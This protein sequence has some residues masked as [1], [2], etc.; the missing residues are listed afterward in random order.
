MRV[1]NERLLHG[2]SE[3]AADNELGL[4]ADVSRRLAQEHPYELV[5]PENYEPG[6][7]Y[8]L[9]VFL[10]DDGANEQHIHRWMNLISRQNF[11]GL[12]IRAPLL[13]TS[14]LPGRFRWARRRRPLYRQLHAILNDVNEQWNIHPQR[15]VLMGE[16]TGALLSLRI[17]LRHYRSFSGLIAIRPEADWGSKLPPLSTNLEGRMLLTGSDATAPS[18]AAA[19]DGLAENG[20]EIYLAPADCTNQELGTT[21]EAWL[22]AG[23]S[24]TIW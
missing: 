14:M 11:L 4:S 16:G 1:P 18:S 19:L 20:A 23:I 17:W 15:I 6:Y 5:L 22:M 8:P 21:I 10:H 7:A 2:F 12:G 9:L 3:A 13:D 24:T